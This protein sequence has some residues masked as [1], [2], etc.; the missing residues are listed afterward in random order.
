M[1][2]QHI[3][4]GDERFLRAFGAKPLTRSIIT[5]L[6]SLSDS[7]FWQISRRLIA[8][9]YVH[10]SKKYG[11]YALTD[12]GNA[13]IK[14]HYL[15]MKPT[16]GSKEVR[17][18]IEKLPTEPH[19]SFFRLLLAEY[20]AKLKFFDEKFFDEK[21]GKE[22]YRYG[23]NH[24]GFLIGGPTTSFKTNT[25][26][27]MCRVLG[28]TPEQEQACI[29]DVATAL[30]KELWVRRIHR[31]GEEGMEALPGLILSLHF[32][33]LDD[34]RQGNADVKR[35]VMRT[36]DGGNRRTIEKT[37]VEIHPCFL[38]TTNLNP[39][40]NE[41]DISED[42]VRRSVIVNTEGL[43]KTPRQY[44]EAADILDGHI[45]VI[46]PNSLQIPFHTLEPDERALIR[47]ILYE[48]VQIKVGEDRKIAVFDTQSVLI[49][50]LGWLILKQG[51]NPKQAIFEVCYDKLVTLETLDLTV[52]G[53]RDL[54]LARYGKYQGEI[55]PDFERKRLEIENRKEEIRV[56]I[57]E[58]KERVVERQHSK[59]ERRKH[60][61]REW[62]VINIDYKKL[63]SDMKK[64]EKLVPGISILLEEVKDSKER[65]GGGKKTQ[66]RLERYQRVF[67]E[68]KEAAGPYL[69]R[70]KQEGIDI[71]LGKKSKE[72]EKIAKGDERAEL[73]WELKEWRRK[74][75][76]TGEPYTPA[77]K[78][79]RDKS[80]QLSSVISLVLKRPKGYSNA[81]LREALRRVK[82][83]AG[84]WLAQYEEDTINYSEVIIEKGMEVV[85]DTATKIGKFL[86]G[87]GG[88][89]KKPPEEPKPRGFMGRT[90]DDL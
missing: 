61:V 7:A 68:D 85:V 86:T 62:A 74:I 40:S 11:V 73:L 88:N 38:T 51:K 52:E 20:T 9:G 90:E 65:F 70:A 58:G 57:E 35:S 79:L 24:S 29:K 59:E 56:T 17:T 84:P 64:A 14:R 6:L 72:E 33:C 12:K 41:L 54:Y 25:A 5:S 32:A 48:G 78:K 87:K 3:L 8:L 60:L 42:R 67:N 27:L 81:Y 71:V 2:K 30:P 28:M 23:E 19:Q 69:A 16:F 21:D 44:E 31:K 49:L 10:Q 46:R 43:G 36:L 18:L 75:N 89:G 82:R 50:V 77:I 83:R 15:T 39:K 80:H 13:Y 55:N 63:I 22:K 76:K 45:P 47:D 53:W 1:P 66:D 26:R 4:P 37:S 34:W